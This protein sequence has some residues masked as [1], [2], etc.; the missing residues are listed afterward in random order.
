MATTSSFETHAYDSAAFDRGTSA[1]IQMLTPEQ[2]TQLLEYQGDERL[3]ERIEELAAK[4][5]EGQITAAEK[6]E[7]E[8]YVRANKFIAILQSQARKLLDA[9]QAK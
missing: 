7:L 6:A 9:R 3:R 1:I 2:A 5:N 8:G 4:N